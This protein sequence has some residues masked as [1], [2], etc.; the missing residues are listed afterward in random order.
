MKIEVNKNYAFMV[1]GAVLVIAGIMAINAYGTNNPVVFGHTAEEIDGL[2]S[3]VSSNLSLCIGQSGGAWNGP[4]WNQAPC[5]EIAD[6]S[7]GVAPDCIRL[8]AVVDGSVCK[9]ACNSS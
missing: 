4:G 3:G 1:L 5:N 6:K 2:S 8:S 7:C 9:W